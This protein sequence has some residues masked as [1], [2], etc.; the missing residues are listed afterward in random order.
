MGVSYDWKAITKRVRQLK[1]PT[2]YFDPALRPVSDYA[3]HVY[4]SERAAGKTTG[5][6]LLGLVMYQMYGTVTVYC[7]PRTTQLAPKHTQDLYGVVVAN[8]YIERITDGKYNNIR[9]YRRKWYLTKTVDGE[10][11]D[12][13][14]N[15]CCHMV[16]VDESADIKSGLNLPTGDLILLDEF[17][18]TNI[19]H[20]AEI[21]VQFCDLISTILRL[22]ECGRI[23][24]LGN[25]I[26]KYSQMYSD[27]EI[28][29]VIE[30]MALGDT[31]AHTTSS[32]TKVYIELVKPGSNFQAKKASWVRRYMGFGHPELA[33]IT[34]RATWA[35]KNYQH[36][37]PGEYTLEMTGIYIQDCNKY[38]R[39]DIVTHETL[40]V[41]LY[42]HWATRVYPDS[43]ILTAGDITDP[44]CQYG[45]GHPA[46]S[47]L[48]HHFAATN[49]IYYS[50]NDVGSFYESYTK[51]I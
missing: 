10:I 3:W 11:V 20:E 14:P 37:P 19:L 29:E 5:W 47:R 34:G 6:L 24:L 44:R 4:L 31:A 30:G 49:R 43:V 1:I 25:T 46:I 17:V 7:R 48:L 32:G 22:R 40:G 35:M 9:Y 42:V 18:S 33:S 26:N 45:Y 39:L 23:V 16:A 50:G 8:D 36:I 27:L 41:C 12:Q 2:E 51:K 28:Q 13:D 15:A 21:F 38:A